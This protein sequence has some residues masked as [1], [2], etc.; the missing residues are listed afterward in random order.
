MYLSAK[1]YEFSM[2]CHLCSNK[3]VIRTDPKSCE[4]IVVSGLEKRVSIRVDIKFLKPEDIAVDGQPTTEPVDPNKREKLETNAFYKLEN[5]NEDKLRAEADNP[6]LERIIELNKVGKDY[7]EWN[8]LL[9]KRHR[10]TKKELVEEEVKKPLNFGMTMVKDL[11][12]KDQQR[13]KQVREYQSASNYRKQKMA[14]RD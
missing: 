12:N 1:I 3:L 6:R 5:A 14:S 4:Y 8:S 13:V 2:N 9:R 10:E 7:F 11:D